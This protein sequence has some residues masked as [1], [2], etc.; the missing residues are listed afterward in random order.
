MPY[1]NVKMGEWGLTTY[2]GEDLGSFVD[3]QSDFCNDAHD[4]RVWFLHIDIQGD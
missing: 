2:P 1:H 3:C 4:L